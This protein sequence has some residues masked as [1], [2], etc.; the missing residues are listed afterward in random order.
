[1]NNT[2][3]SVTEL[4]HVRGNGTTVIIKQLKIPEE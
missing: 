4:F 2:E 3:K 1:M